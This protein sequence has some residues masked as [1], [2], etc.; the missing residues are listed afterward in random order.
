MAKKGIT[1]RN[2]KLPDDIFYDFEYIAEEENSNNTA[3]IVRAMKSKIKEYK[4]YNPDK[5]LENGR[6]PFSKTRLK[7]MGF[8]K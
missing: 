7:K 6:L 5:V 2:Y 8:T 1:L 4:K 3:E